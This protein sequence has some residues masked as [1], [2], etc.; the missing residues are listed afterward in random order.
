MEQ[1]NLEQLFKNF[2]VKVEIK[3]DMPEEEKQEILKDIVVTNITEEE[4]NK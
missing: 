1:M 3:M 2:G 4:N